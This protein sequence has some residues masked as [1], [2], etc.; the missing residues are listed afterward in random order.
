MY[1]N[2]GNYEVEDIMEANMLLESYNQTLT[3]LKKGYHILP[4]KIIS[5]VNWAL[6]PD[7]TPNY[8]FCEIKKKGWKTRFSGRRGSTVYF[9]A[10]NLDTI[11]ELI[12][13]ITGTYFDIKY[14]EIPKT[15][16]FLTLPKGEYFRIGINYEKL[17]PYLIEHLEQII[18]E[19]DNYKT[20]YLE[21][22]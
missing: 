6:N 21:I 12:G 2:V 22:G 18:Y 13:Q 15:D 14:S 16:E 4:S 11:E 8:C 3:V 9:Y 1:C 20:E 7:D 17:I 10:P 5:I 19:L